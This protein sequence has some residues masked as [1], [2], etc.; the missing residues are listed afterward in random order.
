[1]A[2]SSDPNGDWIASL[3]AYLKNYP[4][5][6]TLA[7]AQK[8][9]TWFTSHPLPTAA[10]VTP[11]VTPPAPV[12]PPTG[13]GG[14]GGAVG[15]GVSV[16]AFDA[17]ESPSNP[18]SYFKQAYA[19]G[20]R[21]YVYPPLAWGK[22][23]AR[24]DA[25]SLFSAA[26]AAGLKV[27]LY[28]RD[29]TY[30]SQAIKAVGSYAAHAQ[31]FAIDIET[32]PGL[33]ATQAMVDGITK[34]GVRPIIYSGYGMYPQIMGS[35]N[36]TFAKLPLWDTNAGGANSLNPKTYTPNIL[37]PKPVAYNGW[38]ATNNM[39]IGVQQT[40]ETVYNGLNVDLNSFAA[41]FLTVA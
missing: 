2:T 37:S 38:N 35:T 12:T 16:K 22:S 20:F 30:W 7:W 18:A 3:N 11:P 15:S 13:G 36:T 33:K 6:P 41:D 29:P 10:P 34:L 21:L 26:L 23:T 27:G 8:F 19:D 25:Q 17:T 1:M 40:F 5:K 4:V 14:G 28:N 31:F 9:N 24:S 32:D 39:R